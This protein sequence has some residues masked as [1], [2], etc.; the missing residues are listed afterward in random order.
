ML[1]RVSTRP[2]PVPSA[3]VERGLMT[4]TEPSVADLDATD[5]AIRDGS[6]RRDLVVWEGFPFSAPRVEFEEGTQPEIVLDLAGRL[7]ARIVYVQRVGEDDGSAS[8]LIVGF[9][10]GG[11]VHALVVGHIGEALAEALELNGLDY[12]GEADGYDT[13]SWQDREYQSLAPELQE[14]VDRIVADPV[15]T[16]TGAAGRF[17]FSTNT[18]ASYLPRISPR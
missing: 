6:A 13:S 8:A 16:P 17:Q 12:G 14:A 1:H 2:V 3:L 4:S 7:G 18:R 11:I 5:A 9:A 10:S 15:S